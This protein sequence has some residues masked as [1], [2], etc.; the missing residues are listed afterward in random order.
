MTGKNKLIIGGTLFVL[1]WI[2][3]GVY[4]HWLKAADVQKPATWADPNNRQLVKRGKKIY[5]DICATCH[6]KDMEGPPVWRGTEGEPLPEPPP[7]NATGTTW[8]H[9]DALLFAITKEGGD[10]NSPEDPSSGMPG[11]GD[12]MSD[13]DI[14]AA[15]AY[16]KSRWPKEIRRKHSEITE[17]M[18]QLKSEASQ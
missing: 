16:I 3:G 1:F 12:I 18:E 7:H 6:G 14:W 5:T 9:P 2:V 17:K 10:R 15:L 8:Q 11:F 13:D 4:V